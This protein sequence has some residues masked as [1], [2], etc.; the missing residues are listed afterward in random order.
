MQTLAAWVTEFNSL[1]RELGRAKIERAQGY[2]DTLGIWQQVVQEYARQQQMLDQI[3]SELEKAVATL[4]KAEEAVMA[5]LSGEG[6]QL[7]D[8]EWEELIPLEVE[9]PMILEDKKFLR[10]YKVSQWADKV[11]RLQWQR[12][13]ATAELRAKSKEVEE[14]KRRFDAQEAMHRSCT[15]N[16]S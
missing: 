10:T 7:S 15:W 2:Y 4:S 8:E 13:A 9:D 14:S 1:S 11:T 12:D 5:F 3:S 6:E 16:C